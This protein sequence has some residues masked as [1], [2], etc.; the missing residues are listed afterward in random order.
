[1]QMNLPPIWIDVQEDIDQNIIDIDNLMKELDAR[2]RDR[3]G[4][5]IF[6]DQRARKLDSDISALV[7]KITKL[8][9]DS[10]DRLKRM[11]IEDRRHSNT[12]ASTADVSQRNEEAEKAVIKNVQQLYYV[13]LSGYARQLRSVEK[14]YLDKEQEY[15]TSVPEDQIG[16]TSQQKQM[17][18]SNPDM[19]KMQ[20]RTETVDRII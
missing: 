14:H 5:A 9:K 17:A 12:S 2:K 15:S 20:H 8:I 10:K 7:T 16:W 3:F 4:Q 11:K 18:G 19:I 6:D 1:M 13:K